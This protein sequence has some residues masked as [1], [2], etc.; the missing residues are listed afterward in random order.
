MS[1]ISINPIAFIG[2]PP[3]RLAKQ[4]FRGLS[5]SRAFFIVVR[6]KPIPRESPFRHPHPHAACLRRY[7]LLEIAKS[8]DDAGARVHLLQELNCRCR[9]VFTLGRFIGNQDEM[10]LRVRFVLSMSSIGIAAFST[11]VSVARPELPQKRLVF[12]RYR[13]QFV[14]C[15]QTYRWAAR[16]ASHLP[17]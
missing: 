17:S 8:A 14:R 5:L 9:R 2:K 12:R 13:V 1:P 11:N 15:R 7:L 16:K 4:L 10:Q 3:L 6:G